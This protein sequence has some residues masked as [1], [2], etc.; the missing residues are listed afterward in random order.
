MTR[1]AY[2]CADPGIP[3]FGCKG[4]SIHVQEVIRALRRA[5]ASVSL[6]AA[7]LGGDAPADL[8]DLPVTVVPIASDSAD[9][10]AEAVSRGASRKTG[11]KPSRMP[12][13][14]PGLASR[15]AE[16][17]AR[18]ALRANRRLHDALVADG[19][20]DLVYERY[21]LWSAGAIAYA[22]GVGGCT[23]LLEVN[24]PLI[25]EQAAWREL[26]LP[27]VAQRL[28]SW[29]FRHADG[30]LAVSPGVA[31]WLGGFAGATSRI[32]VVPNGVD[33]ARFA[34]RDPDCTAAGP[35]PA[36]R[37][38]TIGFV[39]TLKPWHGLPT[40]IDAWAR[41]RAS[42]VDARLL[43]VGDGP[44]RETLTAGLRSLGL[45]AHAEL[46]GAVAPDRIPALLARMD[47][48][49][50]PYPPRDDFY[51]SPLKLY[52]YLA[53][54]LPVVCSRVGHLDQV[55]RDGHDGLLFPAGDAAALATTLARLAAAPGLR[56]RLGRNGR[57]R[58]EKGHSW[59]SVAQR[60]LAL[61]SEAT[62]ARQLREGDR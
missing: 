57:E 34:P 4:A 8:A 14:A 46:T 28:A 37:P 3:V 52:E 10:R 58:V 61:A 16:A 13:P 11:R 31:D 7:R 26:P 27:R 53:A 51:F 5:G 2:V 15:L 48:A 32:E 62:G 1:I 20:F 45:A 38:I 59:D 33:L 43:L 30:L 6:H 9:V 23:S 22:S 44:E 39:G 54:G 25:E 29:L 49:V 12:G 47:I 21:S 41:L 35:A 60:I 56:K 17:R 55:I 24:A 18:A 42:G 36:Q 40:L 19:P 50:A